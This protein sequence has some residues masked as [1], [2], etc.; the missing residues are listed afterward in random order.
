MSDW[1]IMMERRKDAMARSR[2]RRKRE[3]DLTV[4]DDHSMAVIQQMRGA[5]QQDRQLNL[6]R[7]AAT[8][9]IQLLP[10]VMAHL[11]K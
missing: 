1:D 4:N 9:K 7:K 2:R 10:T 3:G 8:K 5:A 11:K 6:A